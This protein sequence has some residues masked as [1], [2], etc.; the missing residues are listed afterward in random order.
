MPGSELRIQWGRSQ[1]VLRG[2]GV[3]TIAELVAEFHAAPRTMPERSAFRKLLVEV[4]RARLNEAKAIEDYLQA[5]A[6]GR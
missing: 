2:D 1:Q 3:V 6:D 4:R 5:T